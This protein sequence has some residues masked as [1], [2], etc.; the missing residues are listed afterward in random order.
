MHSANQKEQASLDRPHREILSEPQFRFGQIQRGKIKKVKEQNPPRFFSWNIAELGPS[1]RFILKVGP[2][3]GDINA[4]RDPSILT[5]T[6]L[7]LVFPRHF[8]DV[9][10]RQRVIE[11]FQIIRVPLHCHLRIQARV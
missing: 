11:A 8:A 4:E 1:H 7:S 9:R 6:Q 3:R 5:A 2:F 10:K